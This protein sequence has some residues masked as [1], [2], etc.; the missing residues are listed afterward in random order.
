LDGA[1]YE[2]NLD[3]DF[4]GM[5]IGEK[6]LSEIPTATLAKVIEVGCNSSLVKTGLGADNFMCDLSNYQVTNAE[7]YQQAKEI[8]NEL[9]KQLKKER[10]TERKWK[11]DKGLRKIRGEIFLYELENERW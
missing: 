6:P 3:Q 4:S 11:E 2:I 5:C 10:K 9:D 8:F 1:I 7:N